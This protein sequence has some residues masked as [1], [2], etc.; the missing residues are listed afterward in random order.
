MMDRTQNK[1]EQ[2]YDFA[3]F[4]H[5]DLF[6]AIQKTG[7]DP[8]KTVTLSQNWRFVKKCAKEVVGTGNEELIQKV[9]PQR[10]Y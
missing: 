9:T 6:Q 3:P 10:Y 2:H 7:E 1:N 5:L 8:G 4:W